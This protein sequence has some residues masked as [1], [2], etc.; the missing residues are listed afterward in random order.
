MSAPVIVA[1][2]QQD[3]REALQT[4]AL[5][6]EKH[7]GSCCDACTPRLAAQL[8]SQWVLLVGPLAVVFATSSKRSAIKD[9]G[10]CMMQLFVCSSAPSLPVDSRT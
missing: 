8:L 4:N 5:K 9:K 7:H 2:Q 10:H 1:I 3:K 6:P